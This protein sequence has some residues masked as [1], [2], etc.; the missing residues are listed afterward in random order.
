MTFGNLFRV[1]YPGVLLSNGQVKRLRMKR[2][3]DQRKD[4]STVWLKLNGCN[5]A[6]KGSIFYA[7]WNFMQTAEILC[8]QLRKKLALLNCLNLIVQLEFFN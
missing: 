4:V 6:E 3:V 5:Y 2:S 8:D 1:A 7:N